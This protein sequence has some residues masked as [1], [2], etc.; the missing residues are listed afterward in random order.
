MQAQFPVTH[1]AEL[2]WGKA[3]GITEEGSPP[4]VEGSVDEPWG[5]D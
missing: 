5:E 3:L 4:V 1:R 2:A